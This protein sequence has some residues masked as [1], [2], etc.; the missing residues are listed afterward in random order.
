MAAQN[1]TRMTI[2]CLMA[3][4]AAALLCA[5]LDRRITDAPNRSDARQNL[6]SAWNLY[7]WG[8]FSKSG[9]SGAKPVPDNYREPLPVLVTAAYMGLLGEGGAC[10]DGDCAGRGFDSR[11][12]KRI[13][14]LWSFAVLCASAALAYRL[15]RSGPA[16]L[17]VMVLVFACFLR[18]PANI[19]RL[20]TEMA[21]SACMLACALCFGV[22]ATRPSPWTSLCAGAALGGLALT[23]AIFLYAAPLMIAGAAVAAAMRTTAAPARLMKY[24]GLMCIGVLLTAGPWLIRNAVHFGS[25]QISD[26]G[27]LALYTRALINRMDAFEY[28]AA[29]H[30]WGPGAYRRLVRGTPLH[31]SSLEY[32]R[33]GRA[34]RLNC[35][36]DAGFAGDDTVAQRQGRTEDA[37]SFY[38][39][40]R[41]QR[42]RMQ[43]YFE[44]AGRPNAAH[45]ADAYLRKE[46]LEMIARHPF[47]HMAASLPLAWRGMWC[48]YGGGFWTAFGAA[49][50]AAFV[51]V[52]LYAALKQQ[53]ELVAFAAAPL[54]LLVLNALLTNSLPRFNTPAIPFMVISLAVGVQAVRRRTGAAAQQENSRDS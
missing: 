53:G 6:Q 16:A 29:F 8:V 32:E 10:I 46:A 22:F 2:V 44:Q 50:Y 39:V 7:A 52:C 25:V 45:A 20:T 1:R 11:T 48:F 28:R 43:H 17:V 40:A 30:S 31:V 19:D 15:S 38:A 18:D 21:A 5:A 12:L 13:N 34:A 42:V 26:R 14:L 4:A 37:V 47:R 49:A 24:A 9:P 41:A 3:A 23:K 36:A 33:G 54:C 35:S 51:C 27:G